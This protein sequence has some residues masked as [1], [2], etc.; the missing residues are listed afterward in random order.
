MIDVTLDVDEPHE[1]AAEYHGGACVECDGF[2]YHSAREQIRRDNRRARDLLAHRRPLMRYSGS[3]INADPEACA[4]EAI[5]AAVA[6]LPDAYD[7][8]ERS[9][10]MCVGDPDDPVWMDTRGYGPQ[11]VMD[12]ATFL[13]RVGEA[14][15][16]K[17]A[18]HA[19][20]A[21]EGHRGF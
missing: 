3:E 6:A 7:L 14:H 19:A 10:V 8:I 11:E 13:D 5:E 16:A 15:R 1:A 12:L 20:R 17:K 2:A 9:G 18:R 21:D 4:S